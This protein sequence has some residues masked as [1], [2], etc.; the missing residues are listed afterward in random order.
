MSISQG[1]TVWV[2]DSIWL[3]AVVVSPAQTGFVLVRFEHG[4]TCG[5]ANSDLEPRDLVSR[6]DDKPVSRR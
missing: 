2:W 5:V 3:P 4:V 6:G 1:S